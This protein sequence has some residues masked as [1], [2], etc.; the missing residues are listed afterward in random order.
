MD[1]EKAQALVPEPMKIRFRYGRPIK[2]TE[3]ASPQ[4]LSSMQ[5]LKAFSLKSEEAV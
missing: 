5:G 2:L 3:R 4:V 1:I